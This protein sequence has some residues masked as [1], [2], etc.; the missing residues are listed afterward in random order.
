VSAVELRIANVRIDAGCRRLDAKFQRRKRREVA[1]PLRNDLIHRDRAAAQVAAGCSRNG[2][3]CEKA[4]R[5]YVMPVARVG[6][7][8]PEFSQDEKVRSYFWE[9]SGVAP[10][11]YWNG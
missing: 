10:R 6:R 1:D 8:V 3:T 5:L 9:T 2:C 4:A 11:R 7:A